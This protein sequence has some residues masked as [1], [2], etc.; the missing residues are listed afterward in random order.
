MKLIS[1]A[2]WRDY[3]EPRL[4]VALESGRSLS[5]L[6]LLHPVLATWLCTSYLTFLS[7]CFLIDRANLLPR[8]ADRI[9]WTNAHCWAQCLAQGEAAKKHQPPSLVSLV[10]NNKKAVHV[11]YPCLHNFFSCT[12]LLIYGYLWSYRELMMFQKSFN[13]VKKQETIVICL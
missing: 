3:R 7:F 1:Q 10:S 6:T 2:K 12:V 13:R 4:G 5:F 11:K 8:V 9:K